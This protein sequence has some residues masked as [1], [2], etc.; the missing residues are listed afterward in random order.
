[1]PPGARQSRRRAPVLQ[2]GVRRARRGRPAPRGGAG[3]ARA[4]SLAGRVRKAL[5]L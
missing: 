5:V 1:V 3:T 2:A 4:R